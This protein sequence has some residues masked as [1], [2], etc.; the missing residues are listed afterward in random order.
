LLR[1]QRAN[2]AEMRSVSPVGA[3]R[4]FIPMGGM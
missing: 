4:A 2:S 3:D 1:S